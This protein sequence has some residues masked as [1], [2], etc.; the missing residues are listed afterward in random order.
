MLVWMVAVI[1]VVLLVR[2]GGSFD[3]LS[4]RLGLGAAIGGAA[5][6]VL[7]VLQRGAVVDFIDL[8]VWPTFNIADVAI[9]LGLA[10]ALL[11]LP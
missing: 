4:V 2:A 7:D 3:G 11:P 9:V 6:N 8:R 5:G 1:A 10:L